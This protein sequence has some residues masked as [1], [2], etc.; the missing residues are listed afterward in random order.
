MTFYLLSVPFCLILILQTRAATPTFFC[1]L[2]CKLEYPWARLLFP[3]IFIDIISSELKRR[4]YV[5]CPQP[6]NRFRP[7]HMRFQLHDKWIGECLYY[8][9]YTYAIINK[10][11]KYI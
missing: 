9:I 6:N 11:V 1:L 4:V 2:D 8:I 7:T 10:N 5:G 3:P